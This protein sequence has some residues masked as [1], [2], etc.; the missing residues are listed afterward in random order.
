MGERSLWL[1]L[2]KTLLDT[3]TPSIVGNSVEPFLHQGLTRFIGR[4]GRVIDQ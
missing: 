2:T 3:V 1:I 4:I